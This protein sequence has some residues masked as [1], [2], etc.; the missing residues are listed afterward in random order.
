LG[1]VD[2]LIYLQGKA[3]LL[4]IYIFNGSPES[5][6]SS[7]VSYLPLNF[8]LKGSTFLPASSHS[9]NNLGSGFGVLGALF[10]GTLLGFRL[11]AK[12]PI[13]DKPIVPAPSPAPIAID[14]FFMRVFS[15]PLS[16]YLSF[17]KPCSNISFHIF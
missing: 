1:S 4:F 11:N 2:C 14:A 8:G 6:N 7:R 16:Y 3:N 10:N 9:R 15:L 12:R 13:V 5:Q 17:P